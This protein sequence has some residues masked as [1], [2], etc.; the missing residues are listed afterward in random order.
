M[1]ILPVP[2]NRNLVSVTCGRSVVSDPAPLARFLLKRVSLHNMSTKKA[3]ARYLHG[4]TREEQN[5]LYEQARITEQKIFDTVDFSECEHILEL[6]CGVGAQ[7]EVLL[8]RFP[9]LHITAVDA[10]ETQLAQA[11]RRL[12]PFIEAGRVELLLG[13]ARNT[14][15]K[16]HT[17]DGVFICWLLEHVPQPADILI[18]AHRVLK[19]N[20]EISCNEVLNATFYLEPYSAAVQEYWF[21]FND[22]QWNLEGDPFVGA[23]L[24]ALLIDAGFHRIISSVKSFHY[25]KR[26]PRQR[27]RFIKFWTSLLLSATPSML[28]SKKVSPSLIDRMVEELE[29][30]AK[31]EDSVIFYSWIQAHGFA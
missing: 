17:V 24:G 22:Y 14:H 15:L 5:R 21:K 7:T 28:E 13:D 29:T 10:S 8:R 12:A 2:P 3:S 11:R 23:K 27:K 18:E 26:F 1:G 4:Y 31:A 20:G 6:G 9:D 19:P 25:D 30:A 16:A